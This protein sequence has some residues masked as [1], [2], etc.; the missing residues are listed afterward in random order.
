M[1]SVEGQVNIRDGAK[2]NKSSVVESLEAEQDLPLSVP[3][4]Y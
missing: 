4:D 2:I 3:A 1:S